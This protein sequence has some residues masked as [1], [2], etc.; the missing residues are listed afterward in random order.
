MREVALFW[1]YEGNSMNGRTL[2]DWKKITTQRKHERKTETESL[3]N[4]QYDANTKT[5]T[6]SKL[7]EQQRTK[8]IQFSQKYDKKSKTRD[9]I[10][11][12]RSQFSSFSHAVFEGKS[13]K[14]LRKA[15]TQQFSKYARKSTAQHK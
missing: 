8:N 14:V 2:N 15:V 1:A 12:V 3:R 10:R 4:G 11:I 5:T 9:Y 6:Q 13:E 7:I